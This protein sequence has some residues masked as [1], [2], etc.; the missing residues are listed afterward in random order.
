MPAEH[1]ETAFRSA[2]SGG[3]L[4]LVPF[5]TAGHPDPD[6]TVETAVALAGAGASALELGIPFSDPIADGPVIQAASQRA[7]EQGV[8]VRGA[9]ELA[10]RIRA[11][12]ALPIVAMTYA[13]PILAYGPERFAR[14]AA[15]S[16]V[17]GVILTDVPPE[18]LPALWGVL[19]AAGLA[20]VLLVTP[21]TRSERV[22]RILRDA[23]GYVYVVS[24]TGVTGG[25]QAA[26]GLDALLKDLRGR[27]RLPIAV[28]FGIERPEH[29]RAWRGLADGVVVGSALVKRLEEAGPE[30][31]P[32]AAAA[33]LRELAS[34]SAI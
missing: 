3:R 4:A 17:D 23:T 29:V 13:N 10:R 12:A 25:G 32:A 18:E 2:A 5:L 16:G 30:A 21:L 34:A 1:L 31:A 24:R 15:G 8:N 14:D 7:L 28:G 22:A 20:T 11:R 33:F 6:S 9:L 27:T 19:R 26:A